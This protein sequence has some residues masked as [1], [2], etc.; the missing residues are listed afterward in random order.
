MKKIPLT[1]LEYVE[2]YAQQ[3]LNNPKFFEQQKMLINSQLKSSKATFQNMFS[4][5]N[6]EPESRAYL[7]EIGLI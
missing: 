4:S 5:K 1:D 7:H 2:F 3:L 6:Y